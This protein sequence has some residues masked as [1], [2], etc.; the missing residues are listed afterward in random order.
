MRRSSCV[1]KILWS[2]E[3]HIDFESKA[4]QIG[5]LPGYLSRLLATP[6]QMDIPVPELASPEYTNETLENLVKT[7]TELEKQIE[8]AVQGQV[9]KTMARQRIKILQEGI[10][11]LEVEKAKAESEL[12]DVNTRIK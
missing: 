11:D 6:L 10:E 3:G 4:K 2:S 5:D 8:K 1:G 12:W 7:E 9:E